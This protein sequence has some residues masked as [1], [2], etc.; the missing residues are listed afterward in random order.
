M[1]IVSRYFSGSKNTRFEKRPKSLASLRRRR[2][3]ITLYGNVPVANVR[4]FVRNARLRETYRNEFRSP[5]SYRPPK[6]VS[7]RVPTRRCTFIRGAWITM[8][9]YYISIRR[10]LAVSRWR[11]VQRT[12]Y[13]RVETATY[14]NRVEKTPPPP[15]PCTTNR[16]N[17]VN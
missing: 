11:D 6:R 17:R 3:K 16:N 13:I 1:Y 7:G 9:G 8:I 15:A 2:V 4:F 14:C 5:T 12:E 10:I